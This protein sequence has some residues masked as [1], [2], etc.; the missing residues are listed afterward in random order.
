MTMFRLYLMNRLKEGLEE[1]EGKTPRGFIDRRKYQR[2][3]IKDKKVLL[4]N[5][6]DL[7]LVQN[8]SKEGIST[9]TNERTFNRLKTGDVYSCKIRYRGESYSC[10]IMV[11]WK[12]DLLVGFS[13]E[14]PEASIKKFITRLILP[15]KIAATLKKVTEIKAL[16]NLEGNITWY[17][18]DSDTHVV[19]CRLG[20][21]LKWFIKTKEFILSHD[22]KELSASMEERPLSPEIIN[23]FFS[24]ENKADALAPKKDHLILA[25]DIIMASKIKEKEEILESLGENKH[26]EV[27]LF[28]VKH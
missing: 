6:E 10:K 9:E 4:S 21:K 26:S 5:A 12:K 22:T 23:F 3:S 15:Q 7:L 20:G 16:E 13:I 14:N 27:R 24:P 1:A 19:I 8:I 18:G 28:K 2:F 11:K 17:L 25:E